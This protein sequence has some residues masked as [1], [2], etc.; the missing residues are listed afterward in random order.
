MQEVEAF[1]LCTYHDQNLTS[2]KIRKADFIAIIERNSIYKKYVVS[3]TKAM[4]S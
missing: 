1:Y 2:A 3:I 4:P